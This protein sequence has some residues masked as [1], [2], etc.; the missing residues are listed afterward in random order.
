MKRPE[1]DLELET[2]LDDSP[3][4]AIPPDVEARMDRH[5]AVLREQLQARESVRRSASS[6]LRLHTLKERIMRVFQSIASQR[7]RWAVGFAV[8]A[9][10]V[11]LAIGLIPW[12]GARDLYA[13]A[14]EQFRKARSMTFN[15]YNE[16]PGGTKV[17]YKEPDK[18]RFDMGLVGTVI[19]L[20]LTGKRSLMVNHTLRIYE[21]MESGRFNVDPEAYN[22]IDALRRL[23][24][25]AAARLEPREENS[26]TV[27]GFRIGKIDSF[28][29][30]NVVLWVN[31]R[32]GDP[33]RIE[34]EGVDPNTGKPITKV[35]SD[36]NLDA[37]LDDALFDLTPPEGYRS[38]DIFKAEEKR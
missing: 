33:V 24:E 21:K 20:D 35:L 16:V 18:L 23:P 13:Q 38:I 28:N 29:L 10:I 17:S 30:K 37:D 9:I 14:V 27:V 31:A 36:F 6:R 2:L 15:Y 4:D 12:G 1:I 7:T 3:D 25:K 5:L 19:I 11:S 22:A 26:G 8:T 34:G 32:T